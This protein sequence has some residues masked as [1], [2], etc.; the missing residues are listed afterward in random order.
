[1]TD[2]RLRWRNA[3]VAEHRKANFLH[4][5]VTREAVGLRCA[6][7]H[8]PMELER[9]APMLMSASPGRAAAMVPAPIARRELR[10]HR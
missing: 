9:S 1:M 5:E 10:G 2:C 7:A 4:H 3:Q 6:P 8:T